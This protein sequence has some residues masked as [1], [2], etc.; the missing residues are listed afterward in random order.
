MPRPETA[1]QSDFI[2]AHQ[3]QQDFY[4]EQQ[5]LLNHLLAGTADLDTASTVSVK[6]KQKAILA[7]D[8]ELISDADEIM[9]AM[10]GN[11]LSSQQKQA[12]RI[13]GADCVDYRSHLR[14]FRR[15]REAVL[16]VAVLAGPA[17]FES[18]TI[19]VLIIGACFL[20]AWLLQNIRQKNEIITALLA[21]GLSEE[22]VKNNFGAISTQI[23][24]WE[25]TQRKLDTKNE[26]VERA[27]RRLGLSND[28]SDSNLDDEV[29]TDPGN[30]NDDTLQP[31][32]GYLSAPGI[33]Y[34]YSHNRQS[35]AR[36]SNTPRH[37][38][39]AHSR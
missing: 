24:N 12:L 21:L 30:Q 3:Q 34:Y 2:S 31:R 10:A 38:P 22:F 15:T 17:I 11:Q 4:A 14:F 39:P 37:Q 35:S 1:N 36:T 5:V 20:L 16:A 28:Q 18:G 7:Y 23:R 19:F 6:P 27:R 29:M 26:K 25:K 33:A 13:I 8:G 9:E 32:D